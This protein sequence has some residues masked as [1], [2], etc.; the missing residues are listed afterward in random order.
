M[1]LLMHVIGFSV[2]WADILEE[3]L[4]KMVRPLATAF[5]ARPFY[6]FR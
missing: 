2:L 3:L 6:D 5:L 4:M 1:V